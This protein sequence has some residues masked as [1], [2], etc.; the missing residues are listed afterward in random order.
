MLIGHLYIFFGGKKS[1]L[2]KFFATFEFLVVAKS[3]DLGILWVSALFIYCR[4]LL[5]F[6][7]LLLHAIGR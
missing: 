4:G 7:V 6:S 1:R 5:S 3:Q 2:L